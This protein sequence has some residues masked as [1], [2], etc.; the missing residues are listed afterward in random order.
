MSAPAADV[1]VVGTSARAPA[2]CAARGGL[3][4]YWIDA[5]GDVDLAGAFPG[6]RVASLDDG[7]VLAAA[8][9]GAPDAPWFYG[10]PLENRPAILDRLAAIR[11]LAGNPGEVCARSRDPWQ[12]AD[13]LRA[14][15]LD[16]PRLA[17]RAVVGRWLVKRRDSTGGSGVRDAE[18]G[19][20]VDGHTAVLQAAVAGEPVAGL[21]LAGSRTARLLG[22]TSQLLCGTGPGPGPYGYRG[23]LGPHAVPAQER[24]QWEAIGATL[25]ATFALRGLFG[26]DAIRAGGRIVVVEVNPRWTAAA[27]VLEH[28]GAGALVVAHLA[29]CRG[30]PPVVTPAATAVVYGKAYVF[31]PRDLR[32]PPADRLVA[33]VE[34]EV[35]DVPAPGSVVP[36]GAPLVTVFA[37]AATRSVCEALLDART[38]AAIAACDTA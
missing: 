20:R 15:G 18:P 33:A 25:A 37:S 26:V 7:E 9:Q 22:V 36:A 31:A 2:H 10:A 24:A 11:P 8:L 19:L 5:Y 38:Q 1:I 28:A 3:R 12:V 35:A 6:L 23:S 34:G 17:R 27:E 14:A 29:A 4:P 16:V 32:A 13:A 30:D 21:Y